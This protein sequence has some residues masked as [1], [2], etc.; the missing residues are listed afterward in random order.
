[1][2]LFIGILF[3]LIVMFIILK[4]TTKKECS[5]CDKKE[6]FTMNE[7]CNVFGN[8]TDTRNESELSTTSNR[9]NETEG[10][11]WL[12][13]NFI[14]QDEKQNIKRSN[15]PYLRFKIS[16]VKNE[17]EN[18]YCLGGVLKCDTNEVGYQLMNV[19]GNNMDTTDKGDTIQQIADSL[20]DIWNNPTSG[21][22][23]KYTTTIT[24]EISSLETNIT[25]INLTTISDYI[26]ALRSAEYLITTNYYKDEFKDKVRVIIDKYKKNQRGGIEDVTYY[27]K[28][29]K[30]ITDIS[31]INASVPL[32]CEN[33]IFNKDDTN[34]D[35]IFQ[36]GYSTPSNIELPDSYE[37]QYK[38]E[39]DNIKEQSISGNIN[40]STKN[41]FIYNN[42]AVPYEKVIGITN[43]IKINDNQQSGISNYFN[44]C[45]L[46]SDNNKK[47]Q[48]LLSQDPIFCSNL[49]DL[50]HYIKSN[51][52]RCVSG[53]S[54][55][56]NGNLRFRNIFRKSEQSTTL[57]SLIDFNSK[58][59]DTEGVLITKKI[60]MN[61]YIFV[62]SFLNVINDLN[63]GSSSKLNY[64]EITYLNSIKKNIDDYMTISD[65]NINTIKLKLIEIINNLDINTTTTNTNPNTKTNNKKLIQ[66]IIE[67]INSD[68]NLTE[69]EKQIEIL[70]IYSILNDTENGLDTS[71]NPSNL[72]ELKK[73]LNPYLNGN[74]TDEDEDKNEKTKCI[75]HFGTNVGEPLCCNQSG[76]LQNT[77]Y[78]CPNNTP[79]CANFKCGSEFGTCIA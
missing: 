69:K 34:N 11:G 10:Y 12:K 71:I 50:I 27:D 41:G 23:D 74:E 48:C 6:H 60:D 42:F 78:V 75:A 51:Y 76:V 38:T 45:N 46:L 35:R 33:T 20:K 3:F 77:K 2:K 7:S 8:N 72:N 73:I 62:I 66:N 4:N 79:T 13:G 26:L 47:T 55:C 14:S 70:S 58:F 18:L 37:K 61:P 5:S 25:N 32:K 44:K 17:N 28:C 57:Q 36:L 65:S 43:F 64:D 52:I 56:E 15:E 24:P 29:Y 63:K 68:K 39:Y 40:V 49:K 9:F 67:K 53:S 1:M 19:S 22:I 31:S 16:N 54:N 59:V 30:D 21:I